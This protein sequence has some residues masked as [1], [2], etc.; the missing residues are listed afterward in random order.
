MW[1]YD[2]IQDET[3]LEQSF[4]TKLTEVATPLSCMAPALT[5]RLSCL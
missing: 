1:K 5:P 4:M 3:A 2:I